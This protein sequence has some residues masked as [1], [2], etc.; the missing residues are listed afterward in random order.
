MVVFYT[1]FERLCL[2]MNIEIDYFCRN[3]TYSTELRSLS[4]PVFLKHAALAGRADYLSFPAG[5][6]RATGILLSNLEYFEFSKNFSWVGF[7]PLPP[8]M[9]DPTEH[10]DFSKIIGRAIGD[11]LAKTLLNAKFSH[12]YEA[13]MNIM[14][15]PLIGKR[16]D[17][18]C[19]T[20]TEQFAVEAKA[21]SKTTI[22][23]KSM[24]TRKKQAQ[25]GPLPVHFAFA[26][27]TYNLF[28]A[29]KCRFHDPVVPNAE[30]NK[31]LNALL[32]MNY[33]ESLYQQV[34]AGRQARSIN[35]NERRYLEFEMEDYIF[36][37]RFNRIRLILP[38]AVEE[39]LSGDQYLN[40]DHERFESE[41]IYLD[42]DGVGVHIV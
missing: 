40:M 19:V 38:T 6:I 39:G 5:I 12:S 9:T 36:S 28:G 23:H 15:F 7:T 16:P 8:Y 22:S 42:S 31:R 41:D 24:V 3:G 27:F 21:Y 1:D 26:S 32:A 25:S 4:L 18:Y 13:A 17:L 30:Y 29:L 20:R 34:G 35:I 10:G 2:T 14:G 37:R 11:Y 33:Y